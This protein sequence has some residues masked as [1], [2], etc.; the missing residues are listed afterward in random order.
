MI[1]FRVSVRAE[2]FKVRVCFK[3][4]LGLGLAFD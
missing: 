3:I 1:R 4:R 2:Y